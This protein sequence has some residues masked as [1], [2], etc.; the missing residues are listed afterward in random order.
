MINRAKIVNGLQRTLRT[1]GWVLQKDP[2]VAAGDL[3]Y[4][5]YPERSLAERRFY[6]I[7]AGVFQHRYW[8]NIDY[9]SGYYGAVLPKGYIDHNLM[10]LDA[11]PVEDNVAELVYC[12][13]VI[14]HITNQA[15]LKLISEAHRILKTGGLLRIVVPDAR[16]AYEACL[17]GDRRFFYWVEPHSRP[18]IVRGM[19]RIPPKNASIEQLFLHLVA[20][21]LSEIDIDQDVERKFSTEEI[22]MILETRSMEE[23]LDFFRR[24]CVFKD[25][26]AGTHINWWA[27]NKLDHYFREAGFSSPRLS[28]FGQSRAAPLRDTS[29]FDSTHPKISLYMEAVKE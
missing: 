13:H 17:R 26:Y 25:Q 1:A 7:G 15:A 27:A 3:L 11:F 9:N 14:E 28:G 4:E 18:R 19:Y 2:A 22:A 10:S 21:Q 29:L 12:S 6:N 16:L 8:T 5:G 20:G 24:R 23:A